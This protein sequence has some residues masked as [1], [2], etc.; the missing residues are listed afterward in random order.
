MYRVALRPGGLQHLAAM[1]PSEVRATGE[2]AGTAVGGMARFIRD[3][4]LGIA[5][6]PFAALGILGAPVRVVHDRVSSAAYD[7]VYK[8][9]AAG[10]RALVRLT[11]GN[12]IPAAGTL[13]GSLALG[14]LNGAVGDRL[15]ASGNPLALDMTLR[16]GERDSPRI[17]VFVH[18][19]C[20]TDDAWALLGRR[21]YGAR[22]QEE[23]GYTP[24]Y[25]RYNTGLHISDNGRRLAE[26]LEETVEGGPVPVEEIVLVGHS[27]GGLVARRGA[28]P[29]PPPPCHYG[30][31]WAQLVRHVFCLGAPHLGAP[32]EKAANAAAYALARL[33]ET[34]A[35]AKVVN[36]RS[37]GIK[38]LR[39]GASAEGDCCDGGPD[40]CL[41]DRCPEVP[42]LECATFSFVGAPLGRNPDSLVGDLLV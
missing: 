33:P 3:A 37:V 34:R 16:G 7:L 28:P 13:R 40:E 31:D 29:P 25:L 12:G 20:E 24:L 9:L 15:A 2:L 1:L 30:G 22:L 39:F 11:P 6:R 27:M 35:V 36:G 41:R 19:L 17:A 4:H 18:G 10:P 5:S 38:D 14:A 42:F 23:L 26:L 32:L 8:A 21:P